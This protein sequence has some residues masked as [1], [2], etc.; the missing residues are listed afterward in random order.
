VGVIRGHTGVTKLAGG[1]K[2]LVVALA[3]R[4]A[5]FKVVPRALRQ[6]RPVSVGSVF[7]G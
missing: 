4:C 3:F 2:Q 1:F 7:H 6:R 5:V